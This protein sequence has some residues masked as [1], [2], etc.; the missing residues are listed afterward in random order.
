MFCPGYKVVRLHHQSWPIYLYLIE[1][2]AYLW[3]KAIQDVKNWAS[4]LLVRAC[5]KTRHCQ[6]Q[7][8]VGIAQNIP[9]DAVLIDGQL[10]EKSYKKRPL[11]HNKVYGRERGANTSQC[12]SLF[13]YVIGQ[14]LGTIWFQEVK[15]GRSETSSCHSKFEEDFWLGILKSCPSETVADM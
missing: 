4:V 9:L 3:T 7:H 10:T 14:F 5:I 13:S 12:V 6:R 11:L 15:H 1:S 2:L 8:S